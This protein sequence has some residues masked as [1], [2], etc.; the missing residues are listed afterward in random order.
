MNLFTYAA[1]VLSTVFFTL[2]VVSKSSAQPFPW[3]PVNN[4]RVNVPSQQVNQPPPAQ[5]KETLIVHSIGASEGADSFSINIFMGIANSI[6]H[7]NDEY[8]GNN[9]ANKFEFDPITIYDFIKVSPEVKYSINF[10][11]TGFVLSGAFRP[12]TKYTITIKGGLKIKL[13]QEVENDI[14]KEVTTGSYQPKI[15]FSSKSRY[16]PGAL[17]GNLTF[18]SVNVKE[19]EVSIR[20]VFSQ[21][22]HQWLTSGEQASQYVSEI[23]KTS[24]IKIKAR[25][26]E[27]YKGSISLDEFNPLGH[28]VYVVTAT[29]KN[30]KAQN[31]AEPLVENEGDESDEGAEDGGSY[32]YR[33]HVFDTASVV[34]SNL[35]AVIKWGAKNSLKAWAVKTA[36][37]SPVTGVNVELYTDSNRKIDSCTT[38]GSNAECT[39]KWNELKSAVP[40][41]VVFRTSTD[42]TYIKLSDLAIKNDRFHVGSRDYVKD[43]QGFD[44]FVFSGRD[45]Y[46]PSETVDLAVQVRNKKFE[47]V[48]KIPLLWKISNPKGKIVRE[49]TT[50]TDDFGVSHLPFQTQLSFDTGKYTAQVWTGKQVL[51][52]FSFLVEEF[53]PERIGLKVKPESEEFIN[54]S[55][56]NF[57][58]EALYLFG[59]PVVEGEYKAS[60][61]LVPAFKKIPKNPDYAT[62]FYVNEM[63]KAINLDVVTGKTDDKGLAK[64]SCNYQNQLGQKYPVV[65]EL[66][67][68][69]D[70][71]E[72]GSSRVTSKVGTALVGSTDTLV[73]IK[74][75][76]KKSSEIKI[77]GGFFDFKGNAVKR[78]T[79]LK[80][81]LYRIDQNWNYSYDEQG[82]N[83][84][85]VEEVVVPTGLVKN[86]T[87]NDSVFEVALVPSEG[88][89]QWL[90]RVEDMNTGY[91]ADLNTG[92]LGWYYDNSNQGPAVREPEDLKVEVSKSKI[93]PGENFKVLMQAPFAGRLLVTLE[94]NLV[95]ESK[96]INVSKPGSIEVEFKAPN[97]LPNFY[98]TGLLLKNPQEGKRFLPARAFGAQ[99]VQVIPIDHRM[100]VKIKAPEIMESRKEL[101]IDI[102]NDQKAAVEYTVSVVDEG[103]L[104]MTDFKSPDPIARF[105]E[106]RRLGVYSSET[107]GW[108][109]AGMAKGKDTPGG[110]KAKNQGSQNIPVRLVA[111]FNPVVKSDSSGN[112]TV[113]FSIPEF[114]G[115][116]RVM[117]V[118]SHKSRMGSIEANVT[119]RDPVVIQSTLPR[120]LTSQDK[121]KF[122]VAITNTSGQEQ[123]ITVSIENGPEI[124]VAAG[125][126]TETLKNNQMKILKFPVEVVSAIG[127][128]DIRV[129]AKN[130]DGKI[131][132][133]ESFSL[134]VGPQGVEQS[135][136]LTYKT[137]DSVALDKVIPANWRTDYLKMQ[138][139]I[140]NIPYL[141]EISNLDYLLHY[142]YGCIEQTTSTT[143]PL[144][145]IE[146]LLK[147]VDTKSKKA[148]NVKE[149]VNR[150]IARVLS[151][152][153]GS[154]GFGYW[155]GDPTP[156]PWGTAYATYML[157][158]AKK[159]GYEVSNEAIDSAMTYMLGHIRTNPYNA[160]NPSFNE[161]L[162]DPWMLY[163]LAKGGR[164]VTAEL[165]QSLEKIIQKTGS[166]NLQNI[167]AENNFLLAATAKAL[168]DNES[169]KK[170][171]PDDSLLSDSFSGGR[172]NYY[173]YWSK[174]RSDGLRLTIVDELWPKHSAVQILTQRVVN[175]LRKNSNYGF[176]TQD[177]AWSVL[178]LGKKVRNIN[179]VSNSDLKKMSLLA[180]GKNIP[181]GY[182]VQGMP[183]WVL[184]GQVTNKTYSVSGGA[185][186][187]NGAWLYLNL[188][189]ITQSIPKG[190]GT[191]TLERRYLDRGGDEI[192]PSSIKQG[193]VI[194]VNLSFKASNSM[195]FKNVAIVDRIP[196]GFEIENARLG[197]GEEVSWINKETLYQPEYLDIR[198]DRIQ[199]FGNVGGENKEFYYTVR[200]VTSGQ[201]IAPPALIEQMYEP[202]STTYG[203]TTS[204]Q[205]SEK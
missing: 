20:Q 21:N 136:H 91:T 169:L 87:V 154:G 32:S 38:E 33:T 24:T 141:G 71:E 198:D 109:M 6:S 8:Y 204:V 103:I 3:N 114:Q 29:Q 98:V 83:R 174:T 93:S 23:I 10:S 53:V 73:G 137:T 9:R 88:W 34:V 168:G 84:W 108:T 160:A 121:F 118:A 57:N 179:K 110:D 172:E 194:L 1:R 37:V 178:A 63:N 201:Y 191:F 119:V 145:A 106:P 25:S 82:S 182:E 112:A 164:Q 54:K 129:V 156:N 66:R 151:M 202:G 161:T 51:H 120:F 43:E 61:T 166:G 197:R 35:S 177:V 135:L 113:K 76:D 150:G 95:H 147:F 64:F 183:T 7:Q 70:V 143:L 69:T 86:L 193:D 165:R 15:R 175:D 99:S 97:V 122:P 126:Q 50:Q 48:G 39:L 176:S 107:I 4:R 79:N 36:D 157:L 65:Y 13:G 115:K 85:K 58:L 59:P 195:Q 128:A 140:S 68:K 104:Q 139:T 186:A 189:G 127:T 190:G 41:A 146:D 205:I 149:M 78:S 56:A 133:S 47:A 203:N 181:N 22:L 101:K 45:L 196:A 62:G 44:A 18:E 159:L 67:A 28:G 170:I 14:T 123:K 138:A 16:V 148:R 162:A 105:F 153:T 52:Q 90:V 77:Q 192:N 19:V 96:W 100:Q 173:T 124:K 11:S 26:N 55:E 42:A 144:L 81:R 89:G 2:L 31:I 12:E 74:V 142:P 75:V 187:D 117:V 185:N 30:R 200:A 125:I 199:F 188:T 92:Y 111:F 40:F 152:Q 27:R 116:L 60:C 130:A 134:K 180:N 184:E 131:S 17:A 80:V 5:K 155:P 49:G 171:L 132:N 102:S 46:R 167:Y 72:S 163:V 94:S 158:E